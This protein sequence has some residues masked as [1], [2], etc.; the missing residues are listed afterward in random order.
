MKKHAHNSRQ[1]K[2]S[3]MKE[4]TSK[5]ITST[6]LSKD[7]SLSLIFSKLAEFEDQRLDEDFFLPLGDEVNIVSPSVDLPEE[8]MKITSILQNNC[9]DDDKYKLLHNIFQEKLTLIK[10]LELAI[11]TALVTCRAT[12]KKKDLM[13]LDKLRLR[14]DAESSEFA[15]TEKADLCRSLQA[16]NK[17]YEAT[18]KMVIIEEA[19]M[20]EELRAKC[21][22]SVASITKQIEEE[23]TAVLAKEEENDSLA[24][25]ISQFNSHLIIQDEHLTTQR[26]TRAI[27]QQLLDAKAV[28]CLRGEKDRKADRESYR[29]HILQLTEVTRD[30]E[31]QVELYVDKAYS[32]EATLDDTKFVFKQFEDRRNTMMEEVKE[33]GD[34][35]LKQ[36]TVLQEKQQKVLKMQNTVNSANKKVQEIND[37]QASANKC[38][39]LQSR[40][41]EL[42]RDLAR[43]NVS[44]RLF[45]AVTD[46]GCM[47]TETVCVGRSESEDF[48]DDRPTEEN[49]DTRS[50]RTSPHSF[51]ASWMPNVMNSSSGRSCLTP[52]SS[53]SRS[54]TDSEA[55]ENAAGEDTPVSSPSVH[56]PKRVFGD[57]V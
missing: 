25:K 37:D 26:R 45:N 53:S 1:E 27:E 20:T 13:I 11:S 30:L 40:R 18:D 9:T 16:R 36:E 24:S 6:S 51:D 39:V 5:T 55:K 19:R 7:K 33:I 4:S 31:R 34:Q 57:C 14:Q 50:G 35:L 8:L 42:S 41:T 21:M 46:V 48:L 28:Q 23:E 3:S 47:E 56:S 17:E 52:P 12:H 15:Y 43:L 38:R 2:K 29:C 44:Q 54:W 49:V 10:E 32:F 22:E